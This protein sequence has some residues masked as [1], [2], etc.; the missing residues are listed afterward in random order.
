[1]TWDIITGE[2]I[3]VVQAMEPGAARL[4]FA[5]PPF[6]LGVDYGPH[7]NDSKDQDDYLGWS[8]HWIRATSR[9]LAEDGSLWLLISH[10]WAWRLTGIAVQAGLHHRQTITWFER[11]G[12]NCTGKFNRCTRPLL[13]LVK[14]PRR[15]VFHDCPEIR[16]PSDRQAKYN[17]KRPDPRGKLLDD[18]WEIPRV[19][20]THAERIKGF[21]TQLPI[22]LLRPIVACAPDP[23][24][25]VVDPFSG[26]GTT[27]VACLELGRRYLGI[28]Q[29]EA[30]AIKSRVRLESHLAQAGPDPDAHSLVS[31]P[32]I[33][34][35]GLPEQ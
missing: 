21:P 26:S 28:E 20:G 14:D 32:P 5:D 35:V 6:N 22:R 34:D 30:F 33:S 9:L 7:Y 29:S 10:E 4:V 25:L 8:D 11:F 23:G 1:M 15:F 19:A 17:D 12:V 13:W 16:R 18:L 31:R 3:E 27:G 24:D 2:C